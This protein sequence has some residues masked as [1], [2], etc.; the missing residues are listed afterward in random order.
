MLHR[1]ANP[2]TILVATNLQDAPL[3][4]PHAIN[5]AKLSGARVLLVHVLE[6]AYLRT[7]PAGGLPFLVPGPTLPTVKAELKL[8][9]KQFEHEALVCE[10]IVLRGKCEEE[11]PALARQR[12]VDRVVVGT[13]SPTILNRILLGSVAEFLLHHLDVPVC[14]I[15]P[16][17]CV[18]RPPDRKPTSILVATSLLHEDRTNVNFALDL[19]N[20]N[21]A[22]LAI[23]HVIAAD[24]AN[25]DASHRLSRESEDE[26]AHRISQGVEA[27]VPLTVRIRRG[28]PSRRIL[29]LASKLQADLIILGATSGATS[30]SRCSCLLPGGVAHRVIAEAKIPVIVVPHEQGGSYERFISLRANVATLS[31]IRR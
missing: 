31:E 16:R 2:D 6:P 17:V 20:L 22:H 18:T 10:P 7:Q 24:Q 14:V 25:Q 26:L 4:V 19:A 3:L 21:H 15:G 23:V 28:D 11:I 1:W 5:Q 29:S 27:S 9:E 13:R 30:A 12:D 8:L